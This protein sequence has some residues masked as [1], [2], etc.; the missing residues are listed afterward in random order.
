M[1]G[2][3]YL[4]KGDYDQS[5]RYFQKATQAK[6]LPKD[7]LARLHYSLGLAYE[8]NGM[9][10]EALD[11]FQIALQLDQSFSEAQEKII[12]LQQK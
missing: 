1:L 9:I 12:K 5:I 11:T 7:K 6:G 3:C 2:H 4:D 10:P 8:A